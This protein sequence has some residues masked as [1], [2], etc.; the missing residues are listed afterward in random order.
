MQESPLVNGFGKRAMVLHTRT[1]CPFVWF[2][3]MTFVF[4]V[5]GA[6]RAEL[7][8]FPMT[9][10][11]MEVKAGYY[12]ADG[13]YLGGLP[14]PHTLSR[15]IYQCTDFYYPLSNT[16]S[17]ATYC[18]DWSADES[19]GGGFQ[20]GICECKFP[21][22]NNQYC[23]DWICDQGT[24]VASVCDNGKTDKNDRI[25]N[26]TRPRVACNLKHSQQRYEETKQLDSEPN[27]FIPATNGTSH[28]ARRYL[29]RLFRVPVVS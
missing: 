14:E 11:E 15:E 13:K 18:T 2:S 12:D 6:A 21:A 9:L 17:N 29:P 1:S 27:S 26:R 5:F 28:A 23:S 16:T 7:P 8:D 25:T 22:S 19:F 3:A 24:V 10:D 20:L 4:V